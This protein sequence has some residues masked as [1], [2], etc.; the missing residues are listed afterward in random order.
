MA[1]IVVD[2]TSYAVDGGQNLLAACLSAGL[3]LPYFCWHPAMG[4]VGACRQC[5]V[6][7]FQDDDDRTGR[8][9]MACM[10]P[11]KDG[12]RISIDDREAAEF[13]TGVIEWLMM[14]HPHDCPVCDEGGECHLQD[15]TVM[16][17]HAYRRY[18]FPKRTYRNQD[19]GPFIKHD[20]NRC[21]QC[22]RCVRFY[23]EYAGGR[24]F[25]VFASHDSVYFGRAEDGALENEF[26]GNLVEV[27]PTGVFTDHTLFHH[28]TRKWDLQSAQ[29]ICPHC[30][31]GCNTTPGERYGIL[32][33]IHN[34]FNSQV[35]G[36]FLC[37]RGR[38]GYGF[39]NDEQRI[40]RPLLRAR[41]GAPAKPE[42]VP[43]ALAYAADILRGAGGCLGIGSPRASLEANMA[44]RSLV[45]PDRFCIGCTERESRLASTILGILRDGPVASA[46]LQEIEQCDAVLVLG[47]DVLNTAPRIA[48]ALL[49]SLRQ[50]PLERADALK[51]P[52]WDDAAVRTV[53]QGRSG[54]LF[55]AAYR[56]TWLH[57]HATEE[58]LAEPD[59]LARLGFAA[60]HVAD[61]NAPAVPDLSE[62]VRALA[63][64]MTGA[65]MKAERPLIVAGTAAGSQA[66]IEAA[67]NLAWA[68]H[69]RGKEV[70]LAFA[71]PDCNSLGL[72]MLGGHSL[73]SA[74]TLMR[75]GEIDTAIILENDLYRRA[76][77]SQVDQ[78]LATARGLIAIEA[79]EHRTADFAHVVLPAATVHESDGTFVNHEGRAQ[80]FYQV[81]VPE[82]DI[83]ES[84]RWLRELARASGKP[85]GAGGHLKDL[86]SWRG[87][88]DA[89]RATAQAAS[90]L[91]RITEAAPPS[92]LRLAGQ[93]IPRQPERYSG[94]TAMLAH[95]TV[96]EP[97]PPSDPDS[98]LAFSME[99]YRGPMPAP[100]I[101]QFWAPG[102]NSNQALN[103]YQQ[104]VGGPLR[105]DLPGVRLLEADRAA[106]PR[107]FIQIPPA[108][109]P[110]PHQWLILPW[111][112][113]F[114]SEE[115]SARA[116]AV[117][118]R[119][120]APS[121]ALHASDAIRLGLQDGASIILA[122]DGADH[123][124]RVLVHAATPPGTAGISMLPSFSPAGLPRWVDLRKAVR[125]DRRAA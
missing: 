100:L 87:L 18:R 32:R 115:L 84:W 108:F 48:L 82:G 76:D 26:S 94:R 125:A 111:H 116:P 54:P 95:L 21:I 7:Q 42:G 56:R 71:L 97:P 107:W 83:G 3:N 45:G 72:T 46:S 120:P 101:P 40:R 74:F 85:E 110:R 103:K 19:L 44:L 38:F 67:A 117:Q 29:S 104:E 119:I 14:N 105:D 68:L 86:S 64:R 118:E 99:G 16:T 6:K 122:W 1:T 59:D 12:T 121:L 34:R 55:L 73:E 89:V 80:R 47:E 112:H 69:R 58:Y 49:Q 114:G 13:R 27:C 23:R 60:A 15:M 39:V 2:D 96:H 25:N 65:L 75:N 102:W 63:S 10:T 22:Y 123:A 37:D 50:Q 31:L 17:G 62:A 35:N 28:Y 109:Q 70:R 91:A 41:A 30:S 92:R 24:D 77:A 52:R 53:T 106:E 98:S 90:V 43:Q 20:M 36:Y 11:A 78:F 66:L 33:R 61:S 9:V 113:I 5:A 79:L 51:I 93:K 124:L 4:S 8:L 57:D 88:D 81:F